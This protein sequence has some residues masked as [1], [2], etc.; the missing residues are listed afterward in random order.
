MDRATID[1]GIDLGTINSSIAVLQGT[2]TKVF[3]NNEG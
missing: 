1:F 2:E 3:K